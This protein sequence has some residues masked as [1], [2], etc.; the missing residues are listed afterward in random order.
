MYIIIYPNGNI[1][2]KS[3]CKTTDHHAAAQVI[4][5]EGVEPEQ[6]EVTKNVYPHE[7]D[8][9]GKVVKGSMLAWI[10]GGKE[11][12]HRNIEIFPVKDDSALVRVVLTVSTA[13][14]QTQAE[15]QAD[16]IQ[17]AFEKAYEELTAWLI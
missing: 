14:K 9:R 10:T 6:I 5:V 1:S 2:V 17:D 12:G 8:E 16:T 11:A 4:K 13:G 7:F 3:I 15:G